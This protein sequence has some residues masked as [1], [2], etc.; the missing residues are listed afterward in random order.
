MKSTSFPV[1]IFA[2]IAAL[3]NASSNE[4]VVYGSNA[5]DEVD[6][7]RSLKDADGDGFVCNLIESVYLNQ[8]DCVCKLD[9]AGL[10]YSTT[11]SKKDICSPLKIICGGLETS[12]K[13]STKGVT[14]KVCIKGLEIGFLNL[15][16]ASD[17]CIDFDTASLKSGIKSE[18]G[19]NIT[20][21]YTTSKGAMASK[22]KSAVTG[23]SVSYDGKKCASC[24][25]CGKK[26]SVSFDCSN[27]VEGLKLAQCA[28]FRAFLGWNKVNATLPEFKFASKDF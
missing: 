9:I 8:F 19:K 24:K 2:A 15:P 14:A 10:G 25:T 22:A 11:C 12:V 17:L 20:D 4:L 27:V 5:L 26:G 18:C 13:L 16:I 21:C 1:V 7:A 6:D 3:T 23:C 28:K